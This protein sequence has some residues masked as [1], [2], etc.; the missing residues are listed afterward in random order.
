MNKTILLG[1]AIGT[2]FL[3]G[4]IAFQTTSD[5]SAQEGS[6]PSWIKLNAGFWA[7]DQIT[8]ADFLNGIQYL[9]GKEIIQVP[10]GIPTAKGESLDINGILVVPSDSKTT[11]ATQATKSRTVL[12][13]PN[14]EVVTGIELLTYMDQ[15]HHLK[16]TCAPL[17]VIS[18]P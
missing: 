10:Y 3:L 15:D 14:G 16:V 11:I 2:S 4:T 12:D 7:N 9:I 5:V 1:I 6:I 8:D 17:I 13:C 18:N